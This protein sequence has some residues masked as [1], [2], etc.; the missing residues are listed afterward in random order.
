MTKWIDLR[1][2]TVTGQPDFM[3][4]AMF[5]AVVGDDVYGDDPTITKLETLAASMVG[6]KQPFLYPV[7]LLV[8]SLLFLPTVTVVT[9]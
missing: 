3:R 2:D 7:V 5:N 9:K 4:E 1:S 6:K 8:I